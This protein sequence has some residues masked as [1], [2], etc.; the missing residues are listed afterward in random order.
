MKDIEKKVL[1]FVKKIP[2]YILAIIKWG[3]QVYKA[4]FLGVLCGM[5][6]TP[7]RFIIPSLHAESQ[8]PEGERDYDQAWDDAVIAAAVYEKRKKNRSL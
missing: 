6:G 5:L 8:K 2:V 4:I 7:Y 3:W 1:A